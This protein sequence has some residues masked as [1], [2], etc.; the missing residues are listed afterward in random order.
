MLCLFSVDPMTM[1]M[2]MEML[3]HGANRACSIGRSEKKMDGFHSE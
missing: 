1:V 2:M 3:H